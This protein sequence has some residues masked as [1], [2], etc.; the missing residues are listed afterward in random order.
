MYPSAPATENLV[1]VAGRC[2]GGPRA[3]RPVLVRRGR[4]GGLGGGRG[5]AGFFLASD[6]GWP[7]FQGSR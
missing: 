4:R 5:L 3:D 2:R 1:T 6:Q 7:T